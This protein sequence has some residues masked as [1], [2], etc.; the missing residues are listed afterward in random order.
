[1]IEK[2]E[3]K[4]LLKASLGF[5]TWQTNKNRLP[6]GSNHNQNDAPY[7]GFGVEYLN[8]SW[9]LSSDVV[10]YTGYLGNRDY[11]H[12]FRTQ[13]QYRFNRLALRTEYNYGLQSWDWNTF[14]LG[15]RYY[16]LELLD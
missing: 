7:Y 3:E 12:F 4:L 6:G 10:G 14:S 8:K 1:M 15:V 13:V 9:L 11:P 16:I 5:V 2:E